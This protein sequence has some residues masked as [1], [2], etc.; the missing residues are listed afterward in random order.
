MGGVDDGNRRDGL[1]VK[2]RE[3]EEIAKRGRMV[4]VDYVKREDGSR[5]KKRLG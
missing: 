2:L 1:R 3:G 5:L 4:S